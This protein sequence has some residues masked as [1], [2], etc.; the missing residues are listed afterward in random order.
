MPRALLLQQARQSQGLVAGAVLVVVQAAVLRYKGSPHKD[1]FPPNSHDVAGIILAAAALFVAAGGGIGGGALL[2]PI[3]ILIL[4][5]QPNNAVA[6]SNVT[7]VGGALANFAYNV[8]RRHPSGTKPLVDWDLILVM[9]PTTIL[10]ALLGSYFNKLLPA[11]MTTVLLAVLLSFLSFKLISR[12]LKT[13]QT[14]TRELAADVSNEH[15]GT[16]GGDGGGAPA[17]TGGSPRILVPRRKRRARVSMEQL[18]SYVSSSDFSHVFEDAIEAAE[19]LAAQVADVTQPLLHPGAAPH[20][21]AGGGSPSSATDAQHTESHD[22][23][24]QPPEV[25]A[26]LEGESRQLPWQ[27]LAVLVLLT[28]AVIA[29]D[30]T[31]A[32]VQC[33]SMSYWGIVLALVPLT[34]VVSAGAAVW[35]TR[36]YTAKTRAGQ[37]LIKG[38]VAWTKRNTVVYPA[39]CSLAGLVAGMFGVGGGIVKGPLMLEMGVLPDVAAATSATMILFTAASASAVYIGF[40]TVKEDYGIAMFVVGLTVTFLGQL[41]ANQL[42]VRLKR[43]SIVV[44]SMASLMTL[45]AVVMVVEAIMRTISSYHNGILLKW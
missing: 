25:K 19:K 33:G 10:G 41:A 22:I 39:V 43:R 24:P 27:H 36:K 31:K 29:S 3:L 9:E 21:G 44:F 11:W 15:P 16:S 17:V 26:M 14:E 12:G 4:N 2:V 40:G 1:L 28:A 42:M 8:H 5:F 18:T 45:A 20:N 7:I 30:T 13:Y 35:L 23:L 6:L 38:E 32:Y 37:H 34:A